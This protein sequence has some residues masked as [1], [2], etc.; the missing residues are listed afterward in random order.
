MAL[1]IVVLAL[2][3]LAALWTV[4]TKGLIRSALG[5]AAMSIFVTILM[6]MLG[7]DLAAV[8][9]LS[10]CAGLITVVFVSTISMTEPSSK[11]DPLEK[12][13]NR[14]R[15]NWFLP[16][17]LVT[18]GA[19]LAFLFIGIHIDL[20]P[21]AAPVDVKDFLWKSRQ[22]DLLGQIVIILAGAFGVVTL[23]KERKK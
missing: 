9:E 21:A 1:T 15:H 10:V 5:L 13:R 4:V 14:L 17:I 23:F 3:I 2:T 20:P 19:V 7:A 22:T 12:A 16:V 6:F 8:F 11:P 18:V